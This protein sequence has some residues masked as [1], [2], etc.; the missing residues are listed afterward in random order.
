MSQFLSQT[1]S[2]FKYLVKYFLIHGEGDMENYIFYN[3]LLSRYKYGLS[4]IV[5][6]TSSDSDFKGLIYTPKRFW[7]NKKVL[8]QW[9]FLAQTYLDLLLSWLKGSEKSPITPRFLLQ[10][11]K[12]V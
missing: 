7:E 11:N 3:S 5:K 2:S 1:S 6:K 8:K 4:I 9:Y 10:V 12:K